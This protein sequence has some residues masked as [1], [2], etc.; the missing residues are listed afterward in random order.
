MLAAAVPLVA[1][2]PLLFDVASAESG[3]GTSGGDDDGGGI[4]AAAVVLIVT[5]VLIILALALYVMWP[6]IQT[7]WKSHPTPMVSSVPM[8]ELRRAT[9]TNAAMPSLLNAL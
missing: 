3:S 9:P 2:L 7:L 6:S 5:G 8:Q 1:L 4:G